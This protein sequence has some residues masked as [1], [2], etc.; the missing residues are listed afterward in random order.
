MRVRESHWG[1]T[2]P[3]KRQCVGGEGQG[4]EEAA[5]GELTW[6][7][8]EQGAEVR[9]VRQRG[10]KGLVSLV[11]EEGIDESPSMQVKSVLGGKSDEETRPHL[12]RKEM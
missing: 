6:N 3:E 2:E 10:H 5:L 8:R 9:R 1:R 12:N 11:G 4:V 7:Y